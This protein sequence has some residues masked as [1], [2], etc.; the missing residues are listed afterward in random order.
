VILR[1]A[2]VAIFCAT[3]WA[4]PK[5][6][7]SGKWILNAAESDY[8]SGAQVPDRLVRTVEQRGSSL[9]YKVEREK[10][11]RKGSFDVDLKIGGAP[12]ES[13]AAGV[14]TAEWSGSTLVVKTL[15]NPGSDHASSQEENW[16]LSSDSKKVTDKF[17]YVRPDGKEVHV[18]RVFDKADRK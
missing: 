4:Q 16:T 14:V 5:P 18:T 6:D 3:L 7:F 8:G 2:A 13:D 12:Y 10:D 17:V 11:G 15:F 9:K 1:I